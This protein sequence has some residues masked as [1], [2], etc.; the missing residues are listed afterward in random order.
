MSSSV[1]GQAKRMNE[2]KAKSLNSGHFQKAVSVSEIRQCIEQRREF[3]QSINSGKVI[4][5]IPK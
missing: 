3:V 5:R 2:K 1:H 4:V